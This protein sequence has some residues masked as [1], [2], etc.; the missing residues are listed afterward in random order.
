M[1]A[2]WEEEEVWRHGV[3]HEL[4]GNRAFVVCITYKMWLIIQGVFFNWPSPEFAGD[5]FR[6]GPVKKNHPVHMMSMCL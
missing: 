2:L 1:A 4:L 5:I 3:I 6:G